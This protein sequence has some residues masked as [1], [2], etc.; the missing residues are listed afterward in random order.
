MKDEPVRIALLGAGVFMRQ[1]HVPALLGLPDAFEVVGVFSR[2]RE[3]AEEVAASL[4]GAPTV[5]TDLAGVLARDDVE[6]VDVALPIPVLP[7][8][9]EAA[10]AAGKHVVS[11]K[12]VASTS[13]RAEE[14]LAFHAEHSSRVWMVAENWRYEEC[15]VAAA[16]AIRDGALGRPVLFDWAV[17]VPIRPGH[18]YHETAWRRSGDVPGGF[19][20]DAGVHFAAVLRMAFGELAEA[21]GISASV[22]PDLPPVDTL[23]AALRF[24]S[25]VVGNLAMS[26]AV[27]GPWQSE[28]RV[29]CEDGSLSAS[30]GRLDTTR[31]GHSSSRSFPYPSGVAAEFAAFADAV[32]LG[33]PHR[34]TPA[35]ALSDLRLVEALLA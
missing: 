10:L 32:R 34:N 13:A 31:D 17:R 18:R 20:L 9:V 21:R 30:P 16:E 6:A 35:E 19:L 2:T 27:A 1:A 7:D 8:V 23:A 29:S 11:E 25:G 12:P 26:F 15:F 33:Q 4:P 5:H 22:H 14:L 28:L 3:R 24:E